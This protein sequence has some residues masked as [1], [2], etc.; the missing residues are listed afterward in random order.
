MIIRP[1]FLVLPPLLSLDIDSDAN[2]PSCMNHKEPEE[3]QKGSGMLDLDGPSQR[4]THRGSCCVDREGA[5]LK[6][7]EA[8]IHSLLT[9]TLGFIL[10]ITATR[11]PMS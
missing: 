8:T 9:S 1:S 10:Y 5:E 4:W 11:S 6:R 7:C 2:K 3:Q